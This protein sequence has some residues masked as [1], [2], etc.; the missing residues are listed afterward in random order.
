MI[1]GSELALFMELPEG[2][3]DMVMEEFRQGKSDIEA[4]LCLQLTATEHKQLLNVEEYKEV[5]DNGM[6]ESEAFWMQWARTNI[7]DPKVNTKLFDIMTSR[8]FAWNKKLDRKDDSESKK[9]DTVK[10]DT[11]KFA[12]KFG[13]KAVK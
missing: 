6:A 11:D 4:H 3:E 5:M 1:K 2:W 13:L 7:N 10:K 8:L 9:K 12:Q